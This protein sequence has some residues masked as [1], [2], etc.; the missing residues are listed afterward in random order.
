MLFIIQIPPHSVFNLE[1]YMSS[2]SEA[3]SSL[4]DIVLSYFLWV[5]KPTVGTEYVLTDYKYNTPCNFIL[6][7]CLWNTSIFISNIFSLSPLTLL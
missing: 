4:S 5:V 7:L 6:R 2:F 3:I 1:Y